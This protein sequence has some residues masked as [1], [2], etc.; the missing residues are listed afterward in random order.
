MTYTQLIC[1]QNFAVEK[2]WHEPT[3][4]LMQNNISKSKVIGQKP[5]ASHHNLLIE[6][7]LT[8]GNYTHILQHPNLGPLNKGRYGILQFY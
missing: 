8:L 7:T 6:G 2:P 5:R 1:W 4:K 3:Y